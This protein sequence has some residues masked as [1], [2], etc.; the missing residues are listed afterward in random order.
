[1]TT[2]TARKRTPRPCRS[3]TVPVAG[4]IGLGSRLFSEEDFLNS[5]GTYK[6]N[7]DY[8]IKTKCSGL[9]EHDSPD[10]DNLAP[11]KSK[12][13]RK[14]KR[15]LDGK[16]DSIAKKLKVAG[17]LCSETYRKPGGTEVTY[18][19][20][21]VNQGGNNCAVVGGCTIA[22]QDSAKSIVER[23]ASIIEETRENSE[24]VEQISRALQNRNVY[25]RIEVGDPK[26]RAGRY[27]LAVNAGEVTTT[28]INKEE[29]RKH[30][31]KGNT[32][33]LP[34]R[35]SSYPPLDEV[36][37][38]MGLFSCSC[39]FY[40]GK[41]NEMAAYHAPSG[42]VSGMTFKFEV[43]FIAVFVGPDSSWDL[44]PH[45]QDEIRKEVKKLAEMHEISENLVL[46]FSPATSGAVWMRRDL[47]F[48]LV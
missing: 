20:A 38:C 8:S 18:L 42:D 23:T 45:N 24:A 41:D 5:C 27:Q 36:V 14:G 46:V 33:L 26:S 28:K 9:L 13:I 17:F 37:G 29:W 35:Q 15:R 30:A 47:K 4:K 1:M 7:A 44:G 34:A 10:E 16:I 32:I 48:E 21:S 2:S 12:K 40:F 6:C 22:G 19:R 43:S 39:V 25:T 3:Y 31:P 11:K